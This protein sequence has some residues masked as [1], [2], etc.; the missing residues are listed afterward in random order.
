[1]KRYY[2]HCG[3]AVLHAVD[4]DG[5]EYFHSFRHP[6]RLYELTAC[7][8]CGMSLERAI[9]EGELSEFPPEGDSGDEQPRAAA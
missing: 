9:V 4:D 5:V 6:E 2:H 8:G 7:T 3:A 1:M